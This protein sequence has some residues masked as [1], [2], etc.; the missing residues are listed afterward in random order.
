MNTYND[1]TYNIIDTSKKI[2]N[3]GY[4]T[5]NV[6]IYY[7]VSHMDQVTSGLSMENQ[8]ELLRKYSNDN[9]YKIAGEY[10]DEGISGG[11]IEKR[12][13]LQKL[14][15]DSRNGDMILFTK[16]D[17]FSR[18]LLD[19]NII[20][21]ELDKKGVS[22]KAILEDDIDTSTA[23]G[24]FIFNLK[25]SLAQRE[26]EVVSE[27]I[28]VVF[29]FKKLRGEMLNGSAPFGYKVVD[30]LPV[31]DEN[32]AVLVKWLFETYISNH[33][34]NAT[35][36]LFNQQMNTKHAYNTIRQWIDNP[37]YYGEDGFPPII[38]KELWDKAH[39]IRLKRGIRITKTGNKYLFSGLCY[40]G[41]CGAKMSPH[42]NNMKE[43]TYINY[44]CTDNMRGGK[45]CFCLSEK[46]LEAMM[47]S[48]LHSELDKTHVEGDYT[49]GNINTSDKI[50][51][52][53]QKEKRVKTLYIDGLM[54]HDEMK[55]SI[56][57]IH[58]E[59]DELEQSVNDVQSIHI[60]DSAFEVYK[61]FDKEQKSA[62]WKSLVKE[63][64]VTKE[65]VKIKYL[66]PY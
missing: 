61:T 21:K 22:I 20:V 3:K 9:N 60:D 29:A 12:K 27:R 58:D 47:L 33:S 44:H 5:Q 38:T 14:I 32:Q 54:E 25:L 43:G 39:S 15:S 40:C 34:L 52:L 63:I 11:S 36:K 23:D 65:G 56:K 1:S 4:F 17:R 10:C 13:G 35:T 2:N 49:K 50:N 26:R 6:R 28:K 7:R 55:E 48:E 62:F 16:L 19:A 66:L 57:K 8:L 42:C 51:A 64:K 46:K 53:K 30:K 59:I 24:R 45:R 41:Y 18:N 31:V 37:R